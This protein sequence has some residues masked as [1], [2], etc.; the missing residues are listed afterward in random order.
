MDT[1]TPLRSFKSPLVDL[2]L[3]PMRHGRV[4]LTTE[5][6]EFELFSRL[7]AQLKY[8]VFLLARQGRLYRVYSSL[9]LIEHLAPLVFE[10]CIHYH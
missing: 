8:M 7:A 2:E 1:E 4:D 6:I 9:E 3:G 5:R 10:F